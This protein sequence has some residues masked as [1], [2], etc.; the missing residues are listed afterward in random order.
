MRLFSTLVG[1]LTG[2]RITDSTSGFQAFNAEVIGFLTAD[3]F[4]CDYPDA[5]VL[6]SL[7][8]AGFRISEVPVRMSAGAA[9]K[10]M[11]SGIKPIYY[12]FKMLLSML[13]TLLR[14]RRFYR[15]EDVCR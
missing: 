8:L 14:S 4:P 12:V 13:V 6:I 7:H 3:H 2:E 5:D 15:R 9:G 1:L 11:H 10:S